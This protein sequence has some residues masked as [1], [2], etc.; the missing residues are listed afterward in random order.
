MWWGVIDTP[1][2]ELGLAR[3]CQNKVNVVRSPNTP[4]V[5]RWPARVSP[6]YIMDVN[7]V[8]AD[9]CFYCKAW[10]GWG[11]SKIT[12]N[13]NGV[14]ANECLNCKPSTGQ[15]SLKNIMYVDMEQAD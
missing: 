1:I 2:L 6:K 13:A 7:V 3:V 14:Q 11:V 10:T 9:K 4:I 8:Q 12:A 5:N 15:M